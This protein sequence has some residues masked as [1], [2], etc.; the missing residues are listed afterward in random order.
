MRL[1]FGSKWWE[2]T[3]REKELRVQKQEVWRD[4]ENNDRI[5]WRGEYSR[6]R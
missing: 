6:K 4:S 5:V 1:V 2:K 3:R